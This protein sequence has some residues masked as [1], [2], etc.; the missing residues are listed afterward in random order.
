MSKM[1]SVFVVLGCDGEI[2]THPTEKESLK[3]LQR[4]VGGHIEGIY[5]PDHIAIEN[6][7]PRH[8]MSIYANEEGILRS[9][10]ANPFIG[11]FVG[12]LVVCLTT[13][14][15]NSVGLNSSEVLLLKNKL[16]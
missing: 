8:S 11:G 14:G 1:D 3:Q 13:T 15:G 16:N 6:L 2:T 10:P 5:I 12:N 9:L 4:L 7:R